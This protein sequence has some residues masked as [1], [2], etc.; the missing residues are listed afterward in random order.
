MPPPR[1]VRMR[2]LERGGAIIWEVLG[3]HIH[4]GVL[5]PFPPRG[6]R[7]SKETHF[8]LPPPP[9]GAQLTP[10]MFMG[11]PGGV[12]EAFTVEKLCVTRKNCRAW[13]RSLRCCQSAYRP[14]NML[15]IYGPC[16]LAA[17]LRGPKVHTNDV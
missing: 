9:P 12:P 8:H 2:K 11:D 17:R 5:T 7:N 13:A 14:D 1:S 3:L 4:V 10:K 16:A 15:K 6:Y